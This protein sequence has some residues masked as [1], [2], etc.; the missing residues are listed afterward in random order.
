MGDKCEIRDYD[1]SDAQGKPCEREVVGKDTRG[2]HCCQRHLTKVPAHVRE[3]RE[4]EAK[5][6]R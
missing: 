1:G 3:R 4:R 5:E 6:G 2:R